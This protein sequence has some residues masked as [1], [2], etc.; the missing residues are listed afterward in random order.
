VKLR[1]AL[2]L[3]LLTTASLTLA[4]C[5]SSGSKTP[6]AS[7]TGGPPESGAAAAGAG[8]TGTQLQNDLLSAA[9]L[10]SDVTVMPGS[11]TNSGGAPETGAKYRLSSLDCS[12]LTADLGSEGFGENAMAFDTA[13]DEST[14]FAVGDAIYEFSDATAARTFYTT[15]QT[16]WSACGTFTAPPSGGITATVTVSKFTPD[17][18]LG[19]SD[20]GIRMDAQASAGTQVQLSTVV[21]QGIDVYLVDLEAPGIGSLNGLD[22]APMVK[23][24]MANVAA[25]H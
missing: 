4:G 6:G 20:F 14:G 19:Q 8:L 1:K 22:D 7:P 24:L 21:L 11:E 15:L 17:S 18:G 12:G 2:A 5:S 3:C 25:D 10:P 16:R 23:Q 13:A 9:Q